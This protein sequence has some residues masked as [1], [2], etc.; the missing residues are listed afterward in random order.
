MMS[1]HQ[2]DGRSLLRLLY[3]R[4]GHSK[5]TTLDETLFDFAARHRDRVRLVVHHSEECGH[6]FGR[7]VDGRSPTVLFVRD[8]R[9][10]ADVV[11]DLPASE[12]ERIALA[13]LSTEPSNDGEP[14][15]R[16]A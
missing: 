1:Q 13:A 2:D 7:W 11:G 16:T 5:A 8:G 3:F 12:L 14:L 15:R 4:P 10:I 6:L 9:A